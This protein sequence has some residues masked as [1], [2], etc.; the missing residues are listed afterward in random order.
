MDTAYTI[1]R[2]AR[3]IDR[4][5]NQFQNPGDILPLTMSHMGWALDPIAQM[6]LPVIEN[7]NIVSMMIFCASIMQPAIKFGGAGDNRPLFQV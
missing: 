6:I 3:K 7:V 5:I 2:L 4:W 1:R